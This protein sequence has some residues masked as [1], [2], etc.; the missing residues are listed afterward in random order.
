MEQLEINSSCVKLSVSLFNTDA[1]RYFIRYH[2][3]IGLRPY[4][5]LRQTFNPSSLSMT[6]YTI[7]GDIY[8]RFLFTRILI[9][10]ATNLP[11]PKTKM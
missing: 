11:C 7:I 3:S 8:I 4:P 6:E 2:L 1:D 10:I 5:Y 9:D